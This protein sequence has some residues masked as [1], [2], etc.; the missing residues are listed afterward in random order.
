MKT[1]TLIKKLFNLA[2]F[3]ISRIDNRRVSQANQFNWLK[4]FSIKTIIDVGASK[5]NSILEFHRLFP[6]ATIYA[7]EP[8][9]D[10][11]N[12]IQQKT[13]DISNLHIYN[14]ALGDQAGEATIFRSSYSGAS[15]L[16]PMAELHKNLFP[17]TAGETSGNIKIDTLD[18]VLKSG[19]LADNILVK[20]DVQGYE[21][22]VIKGGGNII[23]RAKVV[24]C[25]TSYQPLYEG[26]PLFAD[27][28]NMLEDLGFIYA[29]IWGEEFKNPADGRPLQQDSIFIKNEI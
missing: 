18:N 7:F 4:N 28:N 8:L 1:K 20:L 17:H 25:E 16:R 6:E 15:S 29:G 10:C 24:V 9:R 11:F 26:Q 13:K 22:K 27:I 12:L 21:D 5:G 14:L 3:K 2:G 19:N 23:K